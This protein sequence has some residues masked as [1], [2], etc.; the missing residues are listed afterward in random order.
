MVH[1]SITHDVLRA[2]DSSSSSS[3]RSRVHAI[4]FFT[5]LLKVEDGD[6]ID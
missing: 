6:E 3:S 4:G 2:R 5:E 1:S